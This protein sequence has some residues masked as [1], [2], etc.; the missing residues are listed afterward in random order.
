MTLKTG[1][2]ERHPSKGAVRSLPLSGQAPWKRVP[3]GKPP[4]SGTRQT[5]EITLGRE[6]EKEISGGKQPFSE[7]SLAGKA[8]KIIH[9]AESPE[10]SLMDMKKVIDGACTKIYN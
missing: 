5:G 9:L 1:S 8:S 4:I 10:K 2:L 7:K 3:M 6:R